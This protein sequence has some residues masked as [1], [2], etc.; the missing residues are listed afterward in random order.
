LAFFVFV[1]DELC[2]QI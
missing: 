2:L 1:T